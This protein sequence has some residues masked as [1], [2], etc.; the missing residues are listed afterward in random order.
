[1]KLRAVLSIPCCV[2]AA[3]LACAA[4][5]GPPPAN[6]ITLK[7]IGDACTTDG[8][9]D[10]KGVHAF[11]SAGKV[12]TIT[13][14]KQGDCPVGFDCGL[15]RLAD[16]TK[17]GIGATCYKSNAPAAG[18]GGF[19]TACGTVSPD[20]NDPTVLCD[21]KAMNPCAAGFTCFSTVKCDGAAY[22][23]RDC[24]TDADCPP[25]AFCAHD[26]GTTCATDA[27]CNLGR[28]CQAVMGLMGTTGKVCLG[29][30]GLCRKREQCSPCGTQDQCP[31][32]FICAVDGNG[33]RY[34]GQSCGADENCPTAF[35]NSPFMHCVDDG[36]G[37]GNTVCQPLQGACHGM[38]NMGGGNGGQCS[39]C[40]PGIPTDCAVGFCVNGTM[41]STG[42]RFCAVPCT[43]IATKKGNLPY[44]FKVDSS[45]CSGGTKCFVAES[46][47]PSNCGASCMMYGACATP[48]VPGTVTCYP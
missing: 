43:A 38:D 13:C 33:E 35:G 46:M 39:W 31:A 42:E 28:T 9:C 6:M 2:L 27:D 1:M 29:A 7:K 23:T 44:S 26:T 22:C 32:G 36:L 17:G 3:A 48:G 24:Q 37:D 14:A 21:P 41:L 10:N 4:C 34:C 47:V 45:A 40:R 8:D 5:G 25:T 19:G 16:G 11:C 12:C 30:K 15:A 18:M 20:P